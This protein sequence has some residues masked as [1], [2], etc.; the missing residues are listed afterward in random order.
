MI[1]YQHLANF[2]TNEGHWQDRNTFRP[3]I[4]DLYNQYKIKSILEIGFNIGY[5]ASMFLEFDPDRKSKVT[6]V[7]IGIHAATVNAAKAVKNLHGDRFSFILSDSKK[8]KKQLK[9]QLFD[10]AFI[11]GDH[12]DPG[13][14]SDIRLCIDLQIP[15]LLFD[16]Y[17]THQDQNG[18]RKVCTQ[19][20]HDQKISQIKVYDLEGIPQ[21]KVAL[22][23]NDTIHTQKNTLARQIST[24]SPKSARD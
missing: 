6:S 22:Y 15:F 8:V 17:W 11:D 23:R 13:V 12:T 14:A 24:L 16:D 18:I 9:G 4:Q 5:S 2:T 1:Q 10:L 3:L 7:D 20:V 19:F 21:P